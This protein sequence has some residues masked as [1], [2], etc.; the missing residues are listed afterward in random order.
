[1]MTATL[2]TT[3]D[4][5]LTRERPRGE[6]MMKERAATAPNCAVYASSFGVKNDD[7]GL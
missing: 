3:M 1:M 7:V 2:D 6:Q 5:H 4:N